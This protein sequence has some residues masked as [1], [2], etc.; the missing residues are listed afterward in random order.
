MRIK[1]LHWCQSRPKQTHEAER[2]AT[3]PDHH[4]GRRRVVISP[5]KNELFR[6]C[7]FYVT[8]PLRDRETNSPVTTTTRSYTLRS[9]CMSSTQTVI[10]GEPLIAQRR[11]HTMLCL[12]SNCN[13]GPVY[14]ITQSFL[15]F[16]SFFFP[17]SGLARRSAAGFILTCR[18]R[19]S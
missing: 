6:A 9:L 16:F 5:S 2:Q 13:R 14:M 15:S 1:R 4:L 17:S 11:Y 12:A 19:S 3:L 18:L 10:F 8:N 7:I